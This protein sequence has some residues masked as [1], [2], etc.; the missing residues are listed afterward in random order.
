[1]HCPTTFFAILYVPFVSSFTTN[2]YLL[3]HIQTYS[4][5]ANNATDIAQNQII[6]SHNMC[7]TSKNI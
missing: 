7:T 2:A 5:K 3:L 4:C 1:M 6:S